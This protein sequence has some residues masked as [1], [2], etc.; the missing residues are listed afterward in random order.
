[1]SGVWSKRVTCLVSIH[2]GPAEPFSASATIVCPME[3]L[4]RVLSYIGDKVT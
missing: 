1:M 4:W 3:A 2:A